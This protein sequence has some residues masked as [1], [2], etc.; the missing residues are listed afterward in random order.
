MNIF[1]G[2]LYTETLSTLSSKYKI[3]VVHMGFFVRWQGQDFTKKKK[4]E[5]QKQNISNNKEWNIKP[6][7]VILL[8][9]T[10]NCI[11]NKIWRLTSATAGKMMITAGVMKILLFPSNGMNWM[12]ENI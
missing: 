3:F 8:S 11:I 6:S 2:I 4:H 1:Y 12:L 7:A 9:W 5:T 10:M